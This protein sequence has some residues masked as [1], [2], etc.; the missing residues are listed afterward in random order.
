MSTGSISSPVIAVI[1]SEDNFL[2]SM[3]MSLFFATFNRTRD[4]SHH[5]T[6][7]PPP[8]AGYLIPCRPCRLTNNRLISTFYY[9]SLLI[10]T[11]TVALVNNL[12]GEEDLVGISR[13]ILFKETLFK[14]S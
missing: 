12:G 14:A 1:V 3:L 6:K 7:S 10:I 9:T 8:Q 4:L 13:R 2:K 5:D 11:L